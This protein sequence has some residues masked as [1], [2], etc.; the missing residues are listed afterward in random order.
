MVD[1]LFSKSIDPILDNI[2]F[3]KLGNNVGIKV[4]FGEKGCKTYMNPEIVRKVYN[5]V[6]SL[7]KKAILIE[8]NVLYKGSRTNST[9]HIKTARENIFDMP[10]DILDGELGEEMVEFD[11]CKIGKGIQKYDSLIIVS[12]FK[13]HL[14]TGFGAA[15]KNVGMGLG[16][17]AG[18]LD[19]HAGVNPF[20]TDACIGC[21]KCI[22]HCNAGAIT[23]V[24]GK[25][26]IDPEKCEG[27]AMCIAV[28]E[29]QA[30]D[31]PWSART[32]KELQLRTAEYTKAILDRFPNT[33]FINILENITKDCDCF[34][35]VQKP[36]MDDV[37]ILA[38]S[39][40]VAID[41]A[42]LDL[43]NKHSHNKF[44]SVNSI[45][46]ESQ[47]RV[48]VNIGLGTADYELKIL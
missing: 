5:K 41:K 15:I 8:C 13:G 7:G 16:S 39:D 37:G 40:I 31:V 34:G 17:R 45:D 33:I 12:H 32:S 29:S 6:I 26:H 48:A 38:S 14:A 28:C 35:I 43:A 23:I 42:S 30:I 20:V 10:I 25:A 24:D 46:K 21:R 44:D 9:D 22:E 18:K 1:V 47:I 27:C 36:V 4:H 11:N 2:D 19:M 3:S